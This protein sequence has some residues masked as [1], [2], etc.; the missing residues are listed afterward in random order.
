MALKKINLNY[1]EWGLFFKNNFYRISLAM[2]LHHASFFRL[3]GALHFD[4]KRTEIFTQVLNICDWKILTFYRRV[5]ETWF[6]LE[7][8]LQS[9]FDQNMKNVLKNIIWFLRNRS[10]KGIIIKCTV[11]RDYLEKINTHSRF[12][13]KIL[14]HMTQH[15]TITIYFCI[16]KRILRNLD[17]SFPALRVLIISRSYIFA[18]LPFPINSL[19]TKSAG[20]LFHS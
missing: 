10:L 6:V 15:Y 9:F 1:N 13:Q 18:T 17:R 19:Y 7:D 8:K 12:T 11:T 4:Y 3:W 20:K 16:N 14:P 2:I 5:L